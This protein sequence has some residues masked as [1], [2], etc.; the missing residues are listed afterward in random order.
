MKIHCRK[1][2]SKIGLPFIASLIWF[3]LQ[4]ETSAASLTF[5]KPIPRIE[6]GMHTGMIGGIGVD[7]ACNLM[8]TGAFDKTVRL[9]NVSGVQMGALTTDER[10]SSK[11]VRTVRLPLN[12]TEPSS[13]QGN[14][15]AVALSP[16]GRY[17]AAAG[18]LQSI[19]KKNWSL[20]IYNVL[21][22]KIVHYVDTLPH[23]I[24][25]LT[26]SEDGR[27]LAATY[28]DWLGLSV[29]ESTNWSEV[30]RDANYN[31]ETH[32][33]AFDNKDGSL[34]TVS[35]DG[36][37][38]RYGPHYDFKRKVEPIP[39]D[40]GKKPYSVSVNPH[41]DLLAVGYVGDNSALSG[42]S[43]IDIFETPSLKP[44]A[45]PNRLELN[46][47]VGKVAWSGDGEQLFAGGVAKSREGKTIIRTWQLHDLDTWKDIEI[48]SRSISHL[49]P[50]GKGI[51]FGTRD[52]AFGLIS[53][54]GRLI[55]YHETV[56]P[57]WS[58]RK[59][60][61]LFVSPDGRRVWFGIGRQVQK[62]VLFDLDQESISI[63]PKKPGRVFDADT[64]SIPLE[65]W[66]DTKWG[67][68][69]PSLS[70]E[71]LGREI[72]LN[73]RPDEYSRSFA[74]RT[75]TPFFIHGSEWRLRKYDK[76]DVSEPQWE[77]QVAGDVRALN[78]ARNGKLFVAAH[79]DGTIRWYRFD[80]G[81]QLLALFVHPA[82]LRW[83]A[84]TPKGYFM[85]SV[86][87]EDLVGWQVDR[88]YNRDSEFYGAFRLRDEY[89]RPTIVRHI[90]TTLN[91]DEAIDNA[92]QLDNRL[93]TT[94][95][96]VDLM[97]PT[98]E[99]THPVPQK[100]T[101][102]SRNLEM[103]KFKVSYPLG[104]DAQVTNVLVQ[105]DGVNVIT[106]DLT[107]SNEKETFTTY[108]P[109]PQS[110][111]V[112]TLV[113]YYNNNGTSV[114]PGKEA[115]LNYVW[116]K[117]DEKAADTENPKL[118]GLFIGLE[119]DKAELKLDWAVQD[120][121]DLE[122]ELRKQFDTATPLFQVGSHF[123]VL[124]DEA[125][126]KTRLDILN[127]LDLLAGAVQNTDSVSHVTV[128]SYSGHGFV[129]GG[130]YFYLLPSGAPS[131][132]NLDNHSI[133]QAELFGKL[134]NIPGRKILL[135]DACRSGVAATALQRRNI[136]GIM[137]AIRNAPALNVFAFAST[138]SGEFSYE[139]NGNGCFTA[140]V[141]EAVTT[142]S[143]AHYFAPTSQTSTGELGDF[144]RISTLDSSGNLHKPVM[145]KS[146]PY[147]K[148]FQLFSH[149]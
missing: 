13:N 103:I 104:S 129:G 60:R 77:R 40:K 106:K 34:Y 39:L 91:I 21:T 58:Q 5:D 139:C 66:E 35:Y 112:V 98:V 141:L 120:A 46:G 59:H 136:A 28:N 109:M 99:I 119:Y 93:T 145:I 124:T 81:E 14:V 149:H 79:D 23:R 94:G 113:P 117:L 82:D 17:V 114:R 20:Y 118:F 32:G 53:N 25:Q 72:L 56:I 1:M 47:N 4:L 65:N 92:N 105:V 142:G 69:P 116:N 73:K 44:L 76:N 131:A 123:K 51:V 86:E 146:S 18:W 31:G 67:H 107:G 134:A 63:T 22:G 115:S 80:N 74:A 6:I 89:Y 95:K 122:K 2:H 37:L 33:V 43:V 41:Q 52:P 88:G 9:W 70:G 49:L 84:W 100:I 143:A 96:L 19:V 64:Y 30:L 135:L 130:G 108:V 127:A 101:K 24:I 78:V 45:P 3:S 147:L 61:R 29:W 125:G 140:S 62:T 38:R 26:F 11:L 68:S 87:G 83:I 54:E 50:C 126:T 42:K 97:P 137:N 36:Y 15:Y 144:V 7:K 90:L 16:D 132:R 10:R 111:T 71:I 148:H 121:R 55:D 75:D 57:D 133:S 128:I 8:A 138:E 12:A 48:G 27:F 85:S 102:F 110:D